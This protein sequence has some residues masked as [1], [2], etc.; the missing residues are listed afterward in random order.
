MF[1]EYH[2]YLDGDVLSTIPPDF[3]NNQELES[4]CVLDCGCGTGAWIDYLMVSTKQA[5]PRM[6]GTIC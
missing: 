3:P 6:S 5:T 4:P 2:R 1:D